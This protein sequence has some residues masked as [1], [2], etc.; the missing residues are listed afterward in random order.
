MSCVCNPCGCWLS[1]FFLQK[2]N[3]NFFSSEWLLSNAIRKIRMKKVWPFLIWHKSIDNHLWATK[4]K[5]FF[6][7]LFS[8]DVTH[9]KHS[10]NTEYRPSSL[11]HNDYDVFASN[12]FVYI[13]KENKKRRL[14]CFF[15]SAPSENEAHERCNVVWTVEYFVLLVGHR[16]RKYDVMYVQCR[17]T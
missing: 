1:G 4:K 11:S 2:L 16:H 6:C 13:Q 17:C 14:Q 5:L 3:R 15:F 8:F 7:R 12:V 9:K 10:A